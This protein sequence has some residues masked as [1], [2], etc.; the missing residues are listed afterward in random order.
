MV[1]RTVAKRRDPYEHV[2]VRDAAT[3]C[4]RF[5]CTAAEQG[6]GAGMSAFRGSLSR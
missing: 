1:V 5:V 3:M 6:A 2:N 4:W